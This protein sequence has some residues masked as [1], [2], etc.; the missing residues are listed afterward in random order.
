M[1]IRV[2]YIILSLIIIH[3]TLLSLDK[4]SPVYKF[5]INKG[6]ITNQNGIQ[7]ND[8]LFVARFH[9]FKLILK[10]NSFSYEFYKRIVSDQKQSDIID[11]KTGMHKSIKPCD[12][13]YKIHRVDIGLIGANENPEIIIMGKSRY[14]N[15]YYLTNQDTSKAE[16]CYYYDTIIYKNIYDGIDLVFYSFNQNS[17]PAF[18]YDWIIHPYSNPDRIRLFYSGTEEILL[19][20]DSLILHTSLGKYTEF[21]PFSYSENNQIINVKYELKNNNL[22]SFNIADYDRSKTLIIDPYFIYGTYYGDCF[23]DVG[24]EIKAENNDFVFA[25]YSS[26]LINIA[27]DSAYQTE[28]AGDKDAILIKFDST[29]TRLWATYY[30]GSGFDTGHCLSL[31]NNGDI[32]L[33]GWTQSKTGMATQGAF[34]YNYSGGEYDSF[35]AKF[36]SE[37][38][39]IWSTYFGGEN[40]DYIND[41]IVDGFSN[42]LFIGRTAS[43]VNISTPGRHQMTFGGNFDVFLQKF[44][45]QGQRIW[46]TYYGGSGFDV[47]ME[48]C[49]DIFNNIMLTGYTQ[50]RNAIAS[51]D[52]HKDTLSGIWDILIAKFSPTGDR[53][54]GTYYGGQNYDYGWGID[55]DG[56][57]N[58]YITGNTVSSDNIATPGTHKDT[59]SENEIDAFVIKFNPHGRRLWGTYFGGNDEDYGNDGI[60]DPWGNFIFSGNTYSEDGIATSGV[61]QSSHHGN[62]DAFLTRFKANGRQDW[63]TYYGG[64]LNDY[65]HGVAIDDESRI[66][67]TGYT[68]SHENISSSNAYQKELGGNS[69]AFAAIFGNPLPEVNINLLNINDDICAGNYIEIPYQ[70]YGFFSTSN[71]FTAQLSNAAGMF[72]DLHNIGTNVSSSSGTITAYLPNELLSSTDYRI[73]IVS[74]HPEFVSPDNGIDLNFFQL[75]RPVITGSKEVCSN[76]EYIYCCNPSEELI[77]KWDVSGGTIIGP[78]NNDTITIK[79]SSPGYGNIKLTETN[80]N[81]NCKDSLEENITI[82][83]EVIAG[84]IKG[85]LSV[86]PCNE[87]IY[88]TYDI[89]GISN[90]WSAKGGIIIG[91]STG[92]SIT[93]IW[94][95]GISGNLKLIQIA[96]TSGC[97]DSTET[98]VELFELPHPYILGD[99]IVRPYSLKIY[100]TTSSSRYNNFWKVEGGRIQGVDNKNMVEILWDNIGLGVITLIQTDKSTNCKDS[101]KANVNITLPGNIGIYGDTLVCANSIYIYKAADT[102]FFSQWNV[103]GGKI[104]GDSSADSVVVI[105]SSVTSGTVSLFRE[106]KS[107]STLDTL[108]LEVKIIPSPE[109]IIF[110]NTEVCENTTETYYTDKQNNLLNHWSAF[111][112]EIEG[113]DNGDTVKIKWAYLS[114]IDSLNVL[115]L[116]RTDT[117]TGCTTEEQLGI[118]VKK[119]PDVHFT[120]DTIVCTN[121][122]I[123]Y[124]TEYQDDLSYRWNVSGGNISDNSGDTLIIVR[125]SEALTG[126]TQLA[127]TTKDGCTDSLRKNIVVNQSPEKPTISQSGKTLISSA[128]QGNQWF[129][130]GNIIQDAIFKYYSPEVS[131]Y[132]TVQVEAT[133]GCLSEMSD[134]YYFDIKPVKDD[135]RIKKSIDIFPNPISDFIEINIKSTDIYDF[136]IRIFSILGEEILKKNI[137]PEFENNIRLDTK[138]LPIGIYIMIFTINREKTFNYKI[139][140]LITG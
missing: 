77:Y 98:T 107:D 118:Y 21:I 26:S 67:F 83:P 30:G 53:I 137:V 57:E 48:L 40:D 117:L 71:T 20:N 59:L 9:N 33:A 129:L 70:V 36:D 60:I 5:E 24:L 104:L 66:I 42:I 134:P 35:L 128:E 139:V 12:E 73:R 63:G 7:R 96:D 16:R 19:N 132:Y 125:W 87:V 88:S 84:E 11:I 38:N 13:R 28:I 1:N 2:Y 91:E 80:K 76:H 45:P 82:Y 50:S 23:E 109:F 31:N 25:G 29:R 52:C 39:L 103:V 15:N 37:G 89:E 121:R 51:Q 32:Y 79:W 99:T 72:I 3:H 74:S 93:I 135:I 49:T 115:I 138:N 136:Q 95:E 34:Q 46:G 62:L 94:D 123:T 120:G 119:N 110:G 27:S 55:S 61:P 78:N 112:G 102:S 126:F 114:I 85:P 4:L 41:I 100:R 131:G 44:T 106:N 105:W 130:E 56:Y 54:W 14:Y 22:V 65:G 90:Y 124:T 58:I 6:Q 92:D 10:N 86:C 127:I 81:T 17:N 101:I 18:K 75:P 68:K 111:N 43:R 69:D 116:S 64:T 108:F 113:S 8:V 47:G 122:D 133:N 97:T 140:K